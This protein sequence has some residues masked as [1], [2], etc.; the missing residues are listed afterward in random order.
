MYTMN[1]NF[2]TRDIY[3][4]QFKRARKNEHFELQGIS[5]EEGAVFPGYSSPGKQC[6]SWLKEILVSISVRRN[7]PR[8][9]KKLFHFPGDTPHRVEIRE[10]SKFII[11][12]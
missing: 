4:P 12:R 10:G 3:D 7:I 11:I 5:M 8:A 2:T 1:N 9:S 6:C